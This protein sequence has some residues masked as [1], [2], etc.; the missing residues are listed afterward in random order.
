MKKPFC[1]D[2]QCSAALIVLQFKHW[3]GN[4]PVVNVEK[5]QCKF[6]L[7]FSNTGFTEKTTERMN[8]NDI[9]RKRTIYH[10]LF[11][12]EMNYQPCFDK[13]SMRKHLDKVLMNKQA[14][15]FNP[16]ENEFKNQRLRNRRL[17]AC[18]K[19]FGRYDENG[20]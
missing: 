12:L 2:I 19:V 11:I 13:F 20:V 4:S 5:L 8:S 16:S 10:T 6:L 1:L 9:S 14:L 15:N 3:E 7:Q 18:Q 17:R